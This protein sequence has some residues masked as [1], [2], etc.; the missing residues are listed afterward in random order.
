MRHE[1]IPLGGSRYTFTRNPTPVETLTRPRV[2]RTDIAATQVWLEKVDVEHCLSS[3]TITDSQERS[4][5]EERVKFLSEWLDIL[6]DQNFL[7]FKKLTDPEAIQQEIQKLA[8]DPEINKRDLET[9]TM[10]SKCRDELLRMEEE[11]RFEK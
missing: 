4:R 9:I 7:P 3:E 2:P 11:T 5:L 8:D 10:L 1:A 6:Q